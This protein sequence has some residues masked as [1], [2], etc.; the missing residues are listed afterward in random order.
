MFWGS[1]GERPYVRVLNLKGYRNPAW[2]TS[3]ASPGMHF[4]ECSSPS[5]DQPRLSG[6]KFFRCAEK[7]TT[8]CSGD[9][10]FT[11][12]FVPSE[13][14]NI[15]SC[16]LPSVTKE[17]CLD[18]NPLLWRWAKGPLKEQFNK[19]DIHLLFQPVWTSLLTRQRGFLKQPFLLITL[20]PVPPKAQGLLNIPGPIPNAYFNHSINWLLP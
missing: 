16:Y 1:G 7:V 15:S 5:S 3:L 17:N 10:K 13:W 19:Q 4:Q 14:S 20:F 12:L 2:V 8:S 6:L 9:G 18:F 11:W